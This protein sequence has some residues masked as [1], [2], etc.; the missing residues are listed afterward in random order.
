MDMERNCKVSSLRHRE[1]ECSCIPTDEAVSFKCRDAM[2][3]GNLENHIKGSDS[4]HKRLQIELWNHY[5]VTYVRSSNVQKSDKQGA[6]PS[7]T[8][9]NRNNVLLKESQGF[10]FIYWH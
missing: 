8:N 5:K 1:D 3:D 10:K 2:M 9:S 4:N 7:K 6:V